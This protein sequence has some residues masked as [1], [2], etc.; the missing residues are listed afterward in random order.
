MQAVVRVEDWLTVEVVAVLTSLSA[1]TIMRLA[2]QGE[3]PRR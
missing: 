3:F 2:K 1:C